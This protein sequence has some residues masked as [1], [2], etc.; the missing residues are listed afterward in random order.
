M[1]K[2]RFS[3]EDG[4]LTGIIAFSSYIIQVP[5]GKFKFPPGHL[6]V[7]YDPVSNQVSHPL[8]IEA[9]SHPFLILKVVGL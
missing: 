3:L 7:T 4:K 9:Y 5:N 1:L 2:R 8:I 6:Q